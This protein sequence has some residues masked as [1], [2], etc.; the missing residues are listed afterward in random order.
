LIEPEDYD[1]EIIGIKEGMK[2]AYDPCKV[3]QVYYKDLQ[4]I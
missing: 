1:N 3:P 2:T 4:A